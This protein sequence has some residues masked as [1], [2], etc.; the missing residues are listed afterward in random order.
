MRHLIFAACA[1]AMLAIAGASTASLA[2]DAPP[3][4]QQQQ[5]KAIHE[6]R[7]LEREAIFDA[8][9]I[10]FK[11]SLALNPDQ[12]KNWPAFE[13]ALR[14]FAQSDWGRGRHEDGRGDGDDP[15]SPV[16]VMRRISQRLSQRSAQLTALADATAPLYASLDD[17]QKVIFR[18]TL[19]DLRRIR[20]RHERHG[21]WR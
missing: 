8:R 7:R 13:A 14:G 9:L 18:A 2:D 1:T 21:D 12:E 5:E 20:Q 16:D 4:D 10:G 15:P 19:A 3:P 6:Q 17:K 11:A